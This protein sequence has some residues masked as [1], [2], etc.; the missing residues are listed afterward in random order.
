MDGQSV[1]VVMSGVALG[2]EA[3]VLDRKI[4]DDIK[5]RARTGR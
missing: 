3:T 1:G 4:H 2:Y 5:A